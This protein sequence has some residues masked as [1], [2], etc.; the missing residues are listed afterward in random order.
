MQRLRRRLIAAF[1]AI[2]CWAAPASA[3]TVG[4][5]FGQYRLRG[6][7]LV[8][9]LSFARSELAAL[10]DADRD[11]ELSAAELAH[12]AALTDAIHVTSGRASCALVSS[13]AALAEADGVSVELRYTCEG[14]AAD[15]AVDLGFLDALPEG[16]RHLVHASA[17]AP[18]I[19]RVAE[20]GQERFDLGPSSEAGAFAAFVWMGVEHI[21]TGYDHLLFLLGVIL[22]GGRLRSLVLALSAFTVA[23]SIT[24]AS[25]ALG[26]F[27]LSPALTEPL[28]ALSVAYVGIE[29]WF[30][31]DASKRAPLTFAFGLI[32]GFG[33][34][35]AL[36]SL[37]LTAAELG[38]ALLAFNL[39]V[40]LAQ[41]ALVAAVLPLLLALLGRPWF[42]A[43]GVRVASG[44]IA[45]VGL[46]ICLARIA[47][48]S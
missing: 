40:E 32:H 19:E 21:A 3:H 35:G 43:T 5:S 8:A 20:R 25:A 6:G 33:F 7:E 36:A 22:V 15:L 9:E 34:A 2:T 11:G 41:L 23:H 13:K 47:S 46:A 30:V 28:I 14:A 26:F 48:P 31:R 17:G 1:G 39:G 16:H 24:L 27:S 29:N 44:A 4:V 10:L 18:E 38:R 12:S 42:R 45:T 37:H